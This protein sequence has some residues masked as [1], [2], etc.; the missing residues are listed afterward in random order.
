MSFSPDYDFLNRR[1][2]EYR[3][4]SNNNGSF[5]DEAWV[6]FSN[7]NKSQLNLQLSEVGKYEI[8]LTV[9]EEFDQPTIPEFVTE[10]DRR[11]ADTYTDVIRQPLIERTIEVGNRAPEVDWTW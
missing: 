2:W 6:I 10:A 3:Y 11:F 9:I 8:K 1:I 7:E 4:D 5:T